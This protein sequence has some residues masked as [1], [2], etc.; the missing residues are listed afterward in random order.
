MTYSVRRRELAP[1]IQLLKYVI[2]FTNKCT[3][4][5]HSKLNSKPGPD[6]RSR[7][8][9]RLGGDRNLVPLFHLTDSRSFTAI[10][11]QKVRTT[12]HNP[13]GYEQSLMTQ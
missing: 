11:E 4:P 2:V 6:V 5:H 8:L 12:K 7:K 13:N 9:N 3:K 1:P 10:L